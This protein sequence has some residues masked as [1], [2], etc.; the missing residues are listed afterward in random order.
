MEAMGLKEQSPDAPE[1]VTNW[2]AAETTRPW[3]PMQD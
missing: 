3:P 1:W 2:I